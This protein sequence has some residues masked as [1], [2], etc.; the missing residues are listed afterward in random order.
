MG[1]G[2]DYDIVSDST[3]AWP[4]ASLCYP[5]HRPAN[6][7]VGRDYDIVSDSIKAWPNAS[8]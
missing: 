5:A 2:R 7:G 1:V 8:C 3:K 4:N 6:M